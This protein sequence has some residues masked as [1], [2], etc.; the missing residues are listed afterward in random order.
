MNE[1]TLVFDDATLVRDLCGPTDAH[2]VLIENA[3]GVRID[4]KSNE[5]TIRG[6]DH[7]RAQARTVVEQL[8]SRLESNLPLTAADVEGLLR[9]ERAPIPKKTKQDT[10]NR[11]LV[12]PRRT[13]APRSATQGQF[14]SQLASDEL[15]FG[16]G[17]AGTGKTYLAVANA[18]SMLVS[19]QVERVIL[20]RPAVEAGE[21]IGFLPGDMK[22]KVDPYLRPLYD[23]LYDVLHTDF[24]DRKL[25]AG[26]IEIAPL[27]FMRGRTLSR[28]AI[29]L[30][31]AQNASI[32]QMKMFL[33]RLG[34]NSRM[35]ITGDPTQT[36]LPDP[37]QSGLADALSLLTKI[38]G[39]SVTRFTGEDVVR[40]RL[41]GEIVRAYD[42][43][44]TMKVPGA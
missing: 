36:D 24:V 43:R 12:L 34:E 14:M 1:E 30:D 10:G 17:P 15:V 40:H 19:G 39:V 27:A 29:I 32:Q 41:V 28:A 33:T 25:A 22:E 38:E 44:D 31:E 37:R 35:A 2:L 9:I 16:V 6:S 42:A 7:A 3:L 11:S 26:E 21:R 20:S 4:A 13:I 8:A 5:V 18:A 23:A